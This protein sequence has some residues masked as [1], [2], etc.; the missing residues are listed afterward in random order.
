LDAALAH[1]DKG[2]Y[3][4]ALP[5]LRTIINEHPG[6]ETALE[7][8]YWLAISY[9]AVG[10]TGDAIETAQDYL[11]IAPNGPHAD[12]LR[13]WN[14][15][16]QSEYAGR[17]PN[18][19][20]L[21]ANINRVQAELAKQPDSMALSLQLADLLWQ[22]GR[23]DEAGV[24]YMAAYQKWPDQVGRDQLFKQRVEMHSDGTHTLLT[25][26]EINQRDRQRNPVVVMNTSSFGSGRSLLSRSR[27]TYVVTGQVLNR[28]DDIIYGIDVLVTIYG[29]GNQV[30]DTTVYRVDRL[31]P[32][33]TRA[34]S[35]SF[36]NFPD[37]NQIDRYDATVS[38]QR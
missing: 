15:A 31:F 1:V 38:Y 9:Q 22:R 10:G 14:K 28:S 33:E 27:S 21:D 20:T 11:R 17:Y 3:R 2:A 13:A 4:Q 37:I 7:A 35:V 26:A 18:I 29:F 23:Y 34:F 30:Y 8:R 12:E 24:A 6:T 19:E 5:R 16:L 32:H 25:P 36:R